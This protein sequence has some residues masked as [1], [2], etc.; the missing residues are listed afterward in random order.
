MIVSPAYILRQI[1]VDAQ[2]VIMPA[3]LGQTIP[4]VQTPQDGST[5]CY[6]SSMPD[7]VDQVVCLYNT[8]GRLFGRLQEGKTKVH[9][10]IKVEVRALDP[11]TGYDL[12]SCISNALDKIQTQTVTVDEIDHYIQSVYRTSPIVELG[13]EVGKKRQLFTLNA[14]MAFQ[15]LEPSLG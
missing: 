2:I 1:L 15:A 3:V 6:V 5:V 7:D 14:R 9:P 11:G 4:F 8:M 12:I 13:E 10:G